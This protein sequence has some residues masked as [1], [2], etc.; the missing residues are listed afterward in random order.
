MYIGKE[1]VYSCIKENSARMYQVQQVMAFF[2]EIAGINGFIG[3]PFCERE[4]WTLM[5]TRMK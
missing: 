3:A 2:G 1:Y 5:E 4:D